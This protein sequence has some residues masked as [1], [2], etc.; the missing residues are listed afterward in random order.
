MYTQCPDCNTAF[1]VTAPVLQRAGGRVVCAGCGLAFN[2]LERLTEDPPAAM[3]PPD[4]SKGVLETLDELTG[5]HQIRIEDTGVE[6]R[7]I[8]EDDPDENFG[9][10]TTPADPGPD[11]DPDDAG[12]VRWY[13]EETPGEPQAAGDGPELLP[14][15]SRRSEPQVS[16]QLAH[17]EDAADP[18]RYDDN[19]PLPEDFVE[20]REPS[21]PQRRAE[22]HIEPRSPE[23]DEAQVDLALGEPGDWMDLLD[24]VG[25][26]RNGGEA[27]PE[28]EK[29]IDEGDN[30]VKRLNLEWPAA[31][32]TESAAGAPAPIA[33]A[34]AHAKADDLAGADARPAPGSGPEAAES[35]PP[36][37]DTQFDLQAIEMGID[38]TGNRDLSIEEPVAAPATAAGHDSREAPGKPQAPAAAPHRQ[39]EPGIEK[40]SEPDLAAAD[41][42]EDAEI[43]AEEAEKRSRERAFEEG[44]ATAYA[45]DDEPA[46]I[47]AIT[48]KAAAPAKESSRPEHFVPAP[49]EEELT[50]NLQIDHDL[51][52]LA[53]Q[54]N[55]FTSARKL[56]NLPLVETII[57]EGETV[58]TASEAELLS[59]GKA[60]TADAKRSAGELTGT[61]PAAPAGD[62]DLLMESWSKTK[63]RVR[64]GR[65][66]TDPPSYRMIIGLAVLG[67]LFAAQVVHAY[68]GSLAT[69]SAFDKTVGSLYRLLGDPVIP[70]WNV[71]GWQFETTSGSTDETGQFLTISSRILNGTDRTLPY[72][73]L[74][75]SLTDRWEEI[76]GSTLLEPSRYLANGADTSSPVAAGRSF[77]AVVR[78]DAPSPDATG[79]K[80][81]V[82]YRE[83][84]RR[85]R[86]ATEDF[87]D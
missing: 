62:T 63:D 28:H 36:D 73:L 79:F 55:V 48:G 76:I 35:F 72:P 66:R 4:D 61:T 40:T 41:L 19:T 34:A 46:A 77:T 47:S 18:Q 2:A 27:K 6:W 13:L 37:I 71:K 69:Y 65:R 16:L 78:I 68:R 21:I 50:V 44:L 80:L 60:D 58:R 57:M 56:E 51:I 22:D 43:R 24:E 7:V 10:Q 52:R 81:N 12:S 32:G 86:C 59:G 14:E 39:D 45:Q 30:T 54:Q 84:D 53:E 20:E 31:A 74:H 49:T 23:A 11:P 9:M 83:P 1:R 33:A 5:P 38:L 42:T 26:A 3:A 8:D 67:L 70:D 82:C 15:V 64:G 25:A 87:K 75:V 85:L 17:A 29:S